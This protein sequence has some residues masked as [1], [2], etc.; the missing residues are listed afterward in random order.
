MRAGNEAMH[1]YEL[2]RRGRE[3]ENMSEQAEKRGGRVRIRTGADG[4][5][6]GGKRPEPPGL[7][8]GGGARSQSSAEPGHGGM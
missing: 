2:P 7:E 6:R 1:Y 8:G 4:A 3:A 5:E